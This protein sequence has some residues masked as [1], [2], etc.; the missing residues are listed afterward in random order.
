MDAGCELVGR[1]HPAVHLQ[2]R[3]F[4]RLELER[5]R[6]GGLRQRLP[7]GDHADHHG[8]DHTDNGAADHADHGWHDTDHGWHDTDHCRHDADDGLD[9][10]SDGVTGWCERAS[11]TDGGCRATSHCG[12]TEHAV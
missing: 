11:G 9:V 5:D 3:N 8:R 1:H 2:R 10:H 6:S 12:L 4:R 7:A